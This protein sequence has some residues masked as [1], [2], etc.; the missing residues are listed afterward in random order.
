[1]KRQLILENGAVFVGEAFGAERVREGEVVFNTG[2]TGYQEILSDPSYCDQIVTMTY[3]LI[4]N[5]GINRDDFESIIPAV[6]GLIVKEVTEVP[7]HWRSESTLHEMLIEKGIPGLAGIDTRRLTKLIREHGTLKGRLCNLETSI[8]ETVQTLKTK[9]WLTD[10]V[11]RVST[12][13]SY[14]SP[15]SGPRIVLVDFG[16]KKGILREV[17]RLGCDV[18]VVPFDTTSEEIL[19]LHPDGIVLSNGPGDPKAVPEAIETVRHLIGK[20]PLFGICLGHQLLALACGANTVKMR[21]G[22]RGANHPV[23]DLQTG[24]FYMTSQNHGYAVDPES[25]ANTDLEVTHIAINDQSIEGLRH[26]QHLAYSV[27]FHPEATPGPED[28][29]QLFEQFFQDVKQSKKVGVQYA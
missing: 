12:T 15:G 23:K 4:G 16:M 8:K 18:L 26:K 17:I 1:M 27:Q 25:L 28:S 19:Q 5:Y 7:S 13:M 9:E 2:M 29:S 10:Q 21:F 11:R 3:P 20:V 22:H 6:A 24:Q 14:E